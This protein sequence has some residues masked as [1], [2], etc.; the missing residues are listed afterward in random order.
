MK[1]NPFVQFLRR[2]LGPCT[3]WAC[4]GSLSAAVQAQTL[5]A[6]L[7]EFKNEMSIPGDN[8]MAQRM[9]QMRD[10][11]KNMPP[12]SRKMMEQQL[13]SQGMAVGDSGATLRLCISPEDAKADPVREGQTEGGCTYTQVS[14]NGNTWKGR[15]ICQEPPSQGDFTT[16]LHSTTHFTTQA[17][18]LSKEHGPVHMTTQARR[19]G[20]DCAA[21]ATTRSR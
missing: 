10:Q 17:R 3:L 20:S 19:L 21:L 5:Q 2:T 4:V 6:G 8:A 15:V 13:A 18:V 9:A 1:R 12:E 7:W 11:L 16:T 14:R